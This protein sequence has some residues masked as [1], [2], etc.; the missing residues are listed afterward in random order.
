MPPRKRA[1]SQPKKTINKPPVLFEKTQQVLAKIERAH[2]CTLLVY[3][4]SA[5]G[6]ISPDDVVVFHEILREIGKQ[7]AVHLFLKSH[8]GSGQSS[9]RIVHL[10]RQ[11][12]D[13][14]TA[15]VPLT[16]ASAATMLALGA[17]DIHMGPLANLSAIDTSITHELSP[18]DR[19]NDLVSVSQDELIRVVR[20]WD[21]EGHGESVNP[22]QS[23][24]GYVH[25]L[26]I[27]A[28][29]RAS[30]LSIQLCKEILSY[31]TNDEKL[32][33]QISNHLNAAY[34]SHTYPITLK[35][36]ER[37]GLEV[38]PLDADLND[39]LLELNELY[40]EMCQRSLT[41]YDEERYHN[42]EILKVVECRGMQLFYQVDKDWY[43]RR[44]ERRWV[45]MNDESSWRQI[46]ARRGKIRRGVFHIR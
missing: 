22:Y 36:A 43:Y 24:F 5:N 3:F 4:S 19:D 26:V 35:E 37:I 44:E 31:H 25:P 30:S 15:L 17:D 8:G 40:S 42:N 29:D 10:L 45:P 41:D 38:K 21:K 2:Q 32:A 16:C 34:P 14:F 39:R 7:S 27:G 1:R 33:E 13:R 28:V 23:L 9:L 11:F 6:A 46:E 12:A 18:L 20:L